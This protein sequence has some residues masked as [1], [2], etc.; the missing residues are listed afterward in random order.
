MKEMIFTPATI[1]VAQKISAMGGRMYLVGGAVRDLF[2]NRESH[3]HDFVV[4]GIEVSAFEE[5]FNHPQMTGNQ[6]PVFRLM[7][8]EEECEI[9]FARKEEKIGEGHNGFKMIFTPSI[10]IEEDLI[11]RDT[12]MNAIAMDVLSGEIIDPF[13]GVDDIEKKIVRATSEHFSEDPLRVLRVARQAT[14]FGFEVDKNTLKL[15]EDCSEE[16]A[17]VPYSRVWGEMQKALNANIP[18]KFFRILVASNTLKCCF[19]EID[20]LRGQTQPEKYHPE[21]DAF[22][23]SMLVL[24]KVAER[25]P[26]LEARF[27]A[28]FHDIGKGL[29]P[30]E[31]LPHHYRHGDK[32]AKLIESW[33]NGRFPAK[34]KTAAKTISTIHM[35]A[36]DLP[37]MTPKTIFSLLEKIKKGC[38]LET[39]REVVLA[40][41]SLSFDVLSDEFSAKVFAKV[42]IP[43]KV[44]QRDGQFI[45]DFVRQVRINRVRQMLH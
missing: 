36:I 28:L 18:D 23:H 10:T 25:T 17:K 14:I 38:N 11:R 16:L 35:T 29:T 43:E 31:E 40:D 41:T 32:G 44:L 39:V 20:A 6:F 19:P 26:S 9:A 24:N 2:M 45:G 34:L 12:T 42:E 7:I 33:E 5:A 8:G 15:M 3:D 13:H 30:K 27:C 37:I 22:E 4:T 1:E 21:G